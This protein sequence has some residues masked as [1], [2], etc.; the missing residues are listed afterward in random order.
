MFV[1]EGY[2]LIVTNIGKMYVHSMK[3]FL[4]FYSSTLGKSDQ[5]QIDCKVVHLCCCIEETETSEEVMR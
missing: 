2:C 1:Q 5:K 3:T 4:L